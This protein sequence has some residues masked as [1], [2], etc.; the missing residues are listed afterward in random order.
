MVQRVYLETSVVSYL[1]AHP[2]RDLVTAARQQLT[3]EWWTLRR[4]SFEVYVSELVVSEAAAGDREAADRRAQ[5]IRDI[6]SLSIPDDAVVL[7]EALMKAAGLPARAG[8][9]ALHISIAAC[10]GMD[11]LLT[12]ELY[13]HRQRGISTEGG[14][15]LSRRRLRTA[16]PLYAR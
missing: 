15:S 1:A 10:H 13:A 2:S 9:D 11:F 5:I 8:A 12:L 4:K 6:P 16:G 3:R 7:A 14:A